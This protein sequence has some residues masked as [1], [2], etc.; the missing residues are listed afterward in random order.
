MK[1]WTS[2]QS[3]APELIQCNTCLY[4]IMPPQTMIK[5]IDDL[6]IKKLPIVDVKN[7]KIT[8]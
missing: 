4:I 2:G 3:I 5:I 1:N 7:K 8:V 6:T